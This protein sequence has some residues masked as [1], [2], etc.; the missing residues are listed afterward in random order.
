MEDC[1]TTVFGKVLPPTFPA[2]IGCRNEIA[3]DVGIG[4]RGVIDIRTV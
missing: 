1:K 3:I 4:I 2:A